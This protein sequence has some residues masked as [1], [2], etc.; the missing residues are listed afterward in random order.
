MAYAMQTLASPRSIDGA[1][2]TAA[3]PAGLSQQL[4]RFESRRNLLLGDVASERKTGNNESRMASRKC[5]HPS[6]CLGSSSPCVAV[7]GAV[8]L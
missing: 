5:A 2:G 6:S 3:P 1:A 7:G 8:V 4:V